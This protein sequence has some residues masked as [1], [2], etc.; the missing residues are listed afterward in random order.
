MAM[1]T[2]P[3]CGHA[4]AETA[5][6]CARCGHKLSPAETMVMGG[7]DDSI[8]LPGT[9]PPTM[10]DKEQA[11]FNPP[12]PNSPETPIAPVPLRPVSAPPPVYTSPP[13]AVGAPVAANEPPASSHRFV[14]MRTIAGLANVLAIVS[15][16]LVGLGGLLVGYQMVSVLFGSSIL[17]A[18]GGLIIGAIA[19]ALGWVYW[20]L[21]GEG[22]WVIL[23]I[24]S[25][26]RRT[27][28][29]LEGQRQP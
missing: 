8:P 20:R 2:C 1:V 24:E 4:N 6:F 25:N 3:N 17:G 27:A 29:A 22:I 12:P 15:L 21:L 5:R 16:V 19:G 7:F 13:P 11:A 23:D 26:T 18:L 10:S 9:R 28:A 14:A